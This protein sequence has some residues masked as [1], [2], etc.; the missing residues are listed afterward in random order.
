MAFFLCCLNQNNSHLIGFLIWY[1]TILSSG[2]KV[3]NFA[4]RFVLVTLWR[5]LITVPTVYS[6]II[7]TKIQDHFLLLKTFS[8]GIIF[9]PS[10]STIDLLRISLLGVSPSSLP[11]VQTHILSAKRIFFYSLINQFFN[12]VIAFTAQLLSRGKTVVMDAVAL[13]RK[14]AR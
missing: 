7:I 1:A 4:T 3:N 13:Q 11:R 12:G 2:K 6:M 5:K 8:G 14:D 9:F 10:S